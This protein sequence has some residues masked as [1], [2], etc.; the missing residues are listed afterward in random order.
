M[1]LEQEYLM[2]IAKASAFAV[3]PGRLELSLSDGSGMEFRSAAA[4]PNAA[5]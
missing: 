5:K 3:T 2:R 1:D 4:A